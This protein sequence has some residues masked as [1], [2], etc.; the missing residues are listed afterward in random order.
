MKRTAVQRDS[1]PGKGS[2]PMRFVHSWGILALVAASNRA[3]GPATVT[4][5]SEIKSMIIHRRISTQSWTQMFG[6]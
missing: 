1:C 6:G 3:D 5:A 4:A 2:A